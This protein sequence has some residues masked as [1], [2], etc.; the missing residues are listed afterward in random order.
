MTWNGG[1]CVLLHRRLIFM[2][3]PAQMHGIQWSST[4]DLNGR[5][6][7]G[8]AFSRTCGYS[9]SGNHIPHY[10]IYLLRWRMVLS[11]DFR[12]LQFK[13]TAPSAEEHEF[14][15][16]G[17]PQFG[18]FS[19]T[20]ADDNAAQDLGSPQERKTCSIATSFAGARDRRQEMMDGGWWMCFRLVGGC[21]R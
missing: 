15:Q 13:A 1:R 12:A 20:K 21:G 16:D 10:D 6:Q 18:D 19:T 7:I 11:H 4:N 5:A 3:Y 14:V 2:K 8:R 9:H 17:G